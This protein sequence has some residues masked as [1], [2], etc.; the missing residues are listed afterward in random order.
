MGNK[1][2]TT[3]W[4][5]AQR[6]CGLLNATF[7]SNQELTITGIQAEKIRLRFSNFYDHQS[8]RLH[9]VRCHRS[10]QWIP[11]SFQG[12]SE[13]ALGLNDSVV[14]DE[15]AL[16]LRKEDI[17]LVSYEL[18]AKQPCASGIDLSRDPC[19][20]GKGNIAYLFHGIDGFCE[21]KGCICAFGDS[22]VEMDHWTSMLSSYLE[23]DDMVL[24]NQGISGNRLL[25]QLINVHFDAAHMAMLKDTKLAEKDVQTIKQI[26]LGSQCF[27]K[28][29]LQRLQHEILDT[30]ANL[31]AVICAIGVNDLYQPGTFCAQRCEL[32][33][34]E[35]LQ[36]GFKRCWHQIK[37]QGSTLWIAGITPFQKSSG[38]DA[39]KENLRIKLNA[40]MKQLH[41]DSYIGFDDLLCD[42][43]GVLMDELH[44]GDHLHP[45]EKGGTIMAKRIYETI[46]KGSL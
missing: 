39:E 41:P 40:W 23:T 35:E 28:S 8:I 11:V 44:D 1:Q 31:K 26:P 21:Q 19:C 15:I 2:W 36:L 46:R 5:H 42:A 17:L 12:A 32:P 30:H 29:G 20:D 27:G 7:Q 34:L 10:H 16:S 6:G 37:N 45:N 18:D 25:R 43:Q 3:L 24:V 22:I 14:C 13:V 4:S 33:S 9:H 38:S